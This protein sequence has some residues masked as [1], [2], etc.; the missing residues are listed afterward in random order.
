[1]KLLKES[2]VDRAEWPYPALL[3]HSIKAYPIVQ[4]AQEIGAQHLRAW[5]PAMSSRITEWRSASAF[6]R[7]SD[8]NLLYVHVPFCPFLCHFCPLYKVESSKE[9]NAV[10]RELFVQ[11]LI[12]EIHLYSQIP[13]VRTVPFHTVYF[14]GGTPTELT[15]A[16]LG[17]ILSALRST[18][19]VK[20]DAEI[21]L[22]GVARQLLAPEYLEAC[23]RAGFNRISFGIQTLDVSLRRRIGR[24]D[25]PE[26]YF[27]LFALAK[28]LDPGVPV[29]VELLAGLPE[30][31]LSSFEH[32]LAQLISWEPSSIDILYYVMMPG[33]GLHRLVSAK[34]RMPPVYGADIL[35]KRMAAN[36][37][38]T[39]AGYSQMTGEVFVRNDRNLF[40]QTSFGGGGH[41]LNTVLAMGPSAFG[42]LNGS[43]YH[44]VCDLSQYMR[45]VEQ[46]LLPIRRAAKLTL[47]TAKR[48][49]LLFAVLQLRIPDSLLEGMHVR[50]LVR[51]WESMGLV[52]REDGGYDLTPLGKLWYNHMQMDLLPVSDWLKSLRMFG[53]LEQLIQGTTNEAAE[54]SEFRELLSLIRNGPV[55]GFVRTAMF[56][57]YL[58]FLHNFADTR[59]VGFTG[60]VDAP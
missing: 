51:K 24:G 26:D 2:V 20:M 8:C 30:Q 14:G 21:T 47:K 49:A 1:M 44:N 15:P 17:R 25:S 4:I 12:R 34:K 18:F 35:L 22:E 46:G 54:G 7:R 3:P 11:T 59:A 52:Q 32:D 60:Y 27:R 29:N 41:A 36:T 55:F 39:S 28:K 53:T 43:V 37:K 23:L 50:Q 31:T 9:R 33:T 16:Q 58:R 6:R 57:V 10:T 42:M 5:P 13:D 19:E 40:V 48:R 38:L 45:T 56:Q